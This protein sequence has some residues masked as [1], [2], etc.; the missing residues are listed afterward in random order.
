MSTSVVTWEYCLGKECIPLTI[1]D[2]G[3][4]LTMR[5]I[6]TFFEELIESGIN[7][8][9]WGTHS[10]PKPFIKYQYM[11][12]LRRPV[13]R[14]DL[15]TRIWGFPPPAWAV[16]NY[17]SGPPAGATPQILVDKTS[18]MTGHLRV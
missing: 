10:S 17:S 16:G 5:E 9:Y 13:M 12:T 6:T 3:G 8:L 4:G 1:L 7:N 11:Y 18:H 14:E 15:S 2:S